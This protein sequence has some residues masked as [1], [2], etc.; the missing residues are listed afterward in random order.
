MGDAALVAAL[1]CQDEGALRE[2][3]LRFRPALIGAA[4]RL[5]VAP[6]DRETAADDCLADVAVHLITASGPPPRSLPAYLARSLRNRVLNG[7]RAHARAHRRAPDAPAS[8]PTEGELA[9]SSEYARRA[10]GA[11]ETVPLSPALKRLAAALERELDEDERLLAVW[12]SNCAPT[13]D[14]ARWLG[15][16]YKAA[17]KR[18]ERLRERL[19]TAALRHVETTTG[20]ERRELLG[21]LGRTSLAPRPAARFAA[22][23]QGAKETA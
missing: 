2:F 18:I 3:Y 17:A 6:G 9:G 22:V 4:A 16:A 20:E 8:G 5:G 7:A 1:R 21:F 23:R 13:R 14:I 12:M 10:S 11:I 19:Q 15:I